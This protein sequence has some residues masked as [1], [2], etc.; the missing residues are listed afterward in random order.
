MHRTLITV[1]AGLTFSNAALADCTWDGRP[2]AYVNCIYAEAQAEAAALWDDSD[3]QA[4]EIA[5]LDLDVS[6]L[7]ADMGTMTSEVD[8]LSSAISELQSETTGLVN[9]VDDL[10]AAQTSDPTFSMVTLDPG[11]TGGNYVIQVIEDS[12]LGVGAIET[13]TLVDDMGSHRSAFLDVTLFAHDLNSNTYHAYIQQTV[14]ATRNWDRAPTLS[15]LSS[16]FDDTNMGVT[17]DITA[18]G[19]DIVATIVQGGGIRTNV[20]YKLIVKRAMNR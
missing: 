3:L 11:G 19:N 9:D 18:D 5:A 7:D 10:L 1:L 12:W 14:V 15:V 6:T 2:L 20:N 17:L 16:D 13:H 8:D 4:A